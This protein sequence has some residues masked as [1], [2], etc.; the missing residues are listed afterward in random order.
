ME[1]VLYG[2]THLCLIEINQVFD[3]FVWVLRLDSKLRKPSS[4]KVLKIESDDR[5]SMSTNGGS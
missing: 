2:S 1:V 4:R 5:V 3:E